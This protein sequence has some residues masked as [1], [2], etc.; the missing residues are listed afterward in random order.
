MLVRMLNALRLALRDS[1]DLLDLMIG[2]IIFTLIQK[3]LRYIIR[4]LLYLLCL[5]FIRLPYSKSRP[6]PRAY[7][8]C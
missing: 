3:V 6:P 5:T 4:T 7:Q 2:I 8:M 1:L